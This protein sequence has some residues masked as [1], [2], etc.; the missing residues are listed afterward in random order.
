[1]KVKV[2]RSVCE[3]SQDA[4][5]VSFVLL[6][7]V[8]GHASGTHERSEMMFNEIKRLTQNRLTGIVKKYKH[9]QGL[10]LHYQK[11]RWNTGNAKLFTENLPAMGEF[12]KELLMDQAPETVDRY[13]NEKAS[14]TLRQ[15]PK[16]PVD[17]SSKPVKGTDSKGSEKVNPIFAKLLGGALED[18]KAAEGEQAGA[19]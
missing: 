10:L 11:I 16:E 19:D 14:A 2:R 17:Q 7:T 13:M 9:H 8:R 1:M 3:A 18:P 12:H 6:L 4:A 5:S 15:T